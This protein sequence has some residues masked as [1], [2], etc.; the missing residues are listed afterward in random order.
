M[1][2]IKRSTR[3]VWAGPRV[4]YETTRVTKRWEGYSTTAWRNFSKW[5][6]TEYPVCSTPACGQPTYYTDHIVPVLQWIAQGGSPMDEGNC[7]PLC[8]KC[9]NSKTGREGNAARRRR[10]RSDIPGGV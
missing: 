3:P 10:E 6:K 1:P 4:A 2:S 9:G 7:Q 8:Y 5:F